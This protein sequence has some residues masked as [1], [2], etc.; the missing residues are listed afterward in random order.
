MGGGGTPT[1]LEEGC[2][3]ERKLESAEQVAH[4]F[5]QANALIF[6]IL[7]RDR[8]K[9]WSLVAMGLYLLSGSILA[10]AT[11]GQGMHG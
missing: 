7:P 9:E 5:R 3:G 8:L 10:Q 2:G 4:V 11:Y 1:G 6:K